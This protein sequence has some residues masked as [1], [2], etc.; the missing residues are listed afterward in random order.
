MATPEATTDLDVLPPWDGKESNYVTIFGLTATTL[1]WV[2]VSGRLFAR[3]KFSTFGADDWFVI[4]ATVN[5]SPPRHRYCS[6][7]SHTAL[8]GH[9]RNAARET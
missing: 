9:I 8:F 4:P 3:R 2:A 6:H 7:I 5:N 1:V